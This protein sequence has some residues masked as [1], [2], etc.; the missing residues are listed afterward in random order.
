LSVRAVA[1]LFLERQQPDRA[2]RLTAAS[3]A[4]FAEDVGGIQLDS[5]NVVD[6]AH[7][8]TRRYARSATTTH[9]IDHRSIAFIAPL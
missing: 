7:Y 5:I 9:P 2:P 3:L 1:A 4:P 6:R 8:L